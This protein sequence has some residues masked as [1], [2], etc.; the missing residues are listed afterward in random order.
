MLLPAVVAYACTLA[1]MSILAWGLGPVAGVG[2]VIFLVSDAM[3]A[4]GAF[5]PSFAPP[6]RDFL[7]MV[8]YVAA[9]VLIAFAVE[10]RAAGG[11]AGR[12][13]ARTVASDVVGR[14]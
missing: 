12:D 1:T 10:R 13:G 4:L 8:T 14:G 9:Q 3:I 2:G 11:T 6:Q 5:A 7:V